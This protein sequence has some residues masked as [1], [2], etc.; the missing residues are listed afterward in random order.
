MAEGY[1][2]IAVASTFSPRFDH[3]LAEAKRMR[4]R[5]GSELSLIYVGEQSADVSERF[6]AALRRRDLPPDSAIH[7]QKGEPAAAILQA[8]EE[9]ALELIIAGALEKAVVLHPFLGTVARQLLRD[10]QTSL[11]LFTQPAEEPAPLRIMT[12]VADYSEHGRDAL[13]RAL[14]LATQEKTERFYVVRV[15]TTFDEA[16]A[17][18][19]KE[20]RVDEESRLEHFVL[21]VG[22]I[23][24]PTEVRCLR[25]NTG[26]AVADFVHSVNADLLIV[27]V[28]AGKSASGLPPNL[29][30]LLEVI[31]C[32]LWIIR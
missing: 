4:D 32:N 19:D 22:T 30:W 9:N 11:I 2:K 29:E 27:P 14:A 31:P 26:F 10:G 21:S 12:F 8:A 25:G 16:R 5:F 15:V 17:A 28:A 1:Q 13:R 7:Y 6:N 23:D 3:V 18:R 20:A 24:V